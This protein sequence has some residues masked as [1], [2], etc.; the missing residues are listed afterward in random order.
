M[1]N[2]ILEIDAMRGMAIIAMIAYHLFFD[3][4]YFNIIDIPVTEGV[5][6]VFARSVATTF[7]LVVGIA[8]AVKQARNPP[9]FHYFWQGVKIGLCALGITVVTLLVVPDAFIFFGILHLIAISTIIAPLF[10]RRK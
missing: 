9:Y 6:K 8:L 3:L 7:L 2:R 10:F 4:D 1:K 5:W